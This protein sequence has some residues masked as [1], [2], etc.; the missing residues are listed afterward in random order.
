MPRGVSSNIYVLE[1]EDGRSWLSI[2]QGELTVGAAFTLADQHR[3]G[4]VR[5]RKG[6]ERIIAVWVDGVRLDDRRWQQERHFT[7]VG[8]RRPKSFGQFAPKVAK[9]PVVE[10]S[11]SAAEEAEHYAKVQAAK[12]AK[13]DP[14]LKPD[15]V[16][17]VRPVVRGYRPGV[18]PV[19]FDVVFDGR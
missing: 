17:P 13:I 10:I 9:A 12:Q 18:G 4:T 19:E 16:A 6:K 8:R 14:L 7:K 15:Y 11:L 1:R 3:S 2:C 5:L